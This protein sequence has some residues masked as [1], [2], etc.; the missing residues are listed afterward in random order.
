MRIRY[1]TALGIFILICAAFILGTTLLIGVS[2][3]TLSGVLFVIIG[4]GYMTRPLAE[5]T[6]REL[7][8]FALFGPMK[9]HYPIEALR[10]V[11][12]RLYA[13]TKKV[14]LVAWTANGDDLR[15]VV[16][17]VQSRIAS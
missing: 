8:V 12:G 3:N 9:K 7:T 6:D 10:V 13:G 11:D 16:Q 14:G 1:N 17:R 5:L 15:A 4:I 2:L